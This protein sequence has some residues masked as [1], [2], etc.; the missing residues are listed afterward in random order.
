MAATCDVKSG[1]VE[2]A[3]ICKK[4]LPIAGK[5]VIFSMFVLVSLLAGA[6]AQRQPKRMHIF[7]APHFCSILNGSVLDSSPI[8]TSL[9]GPAVTLRW[10]EEVHLNDVLLTSLLPV[11]DG[12]TGKIGTKE[13]SDFFNTKMLHPTSKVRGANNLVLEKV[14]NSRVCICLLCVCVLLLLN[15]SC[16]LTV[17]PHHTSIFILHIF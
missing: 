1:N 16:S 2:L 14:I 10:Q 11:V 3:D 6:S 4:I 13:M 8:G 15:H 7:A 17:V 12:A 9:A 5:C